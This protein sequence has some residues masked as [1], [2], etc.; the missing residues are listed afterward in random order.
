MGIMAAIDS[1]GTGAFLSV[2]AIFLTRS[3]GLS[4]AQ[5]GLGLGCGAAVGLFTTVPVGGLADR[6]GPRR[7]L[8]GVSLWRAA[9]YV[10]YPFVTSFA[11][12][13]A[14]VCV[15]GLVNEV[16]APMEQAMVS[17]AVPPD[18]R[19]HT[20][21]VMRSLRN[22]GFTVGVLLGGVALVADNWTAYAIVLFANAAS[23]V[24]LAVIAVTLPLA[25]AT[26]SA[27]ARREISLKVLADRPFLVLTGINAILTLHMPLLSVGIPLWIAEHSHAPRAIVG[28]L[29][30]VNTIL[31]ITLQVRASR[32]S[33]SPPGA[34]RRLRQ[35]GLALAVCCLLLAL[36]PRLG[37]VPAIA[38]LVAAMVALTGGELWQSAGGWGLSYALARPGQEGA[39]LSMFSL[40][41]AVQQIAAPVLV[42]TVVQ[43][44]TVGWVGL[45]ALVAVTG[46]IAPLTAT[47]ASRSMRPERSDESLCETA[48]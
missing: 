44:G 24:I 7:V 3:V 40:G 33:D 20:M 37:M 6:Y 23:F 19:V 5:V 16:A 35:A 29:L 32:G 31:C 22:V 21:A 1:A 39:Y 41:A 36:L 11:T 42:A 43:V 13:A 4:V 14:L 47:W 8:V 10:V 48:A 26:G 38:L 2:S 46:L 25:A 18:D 45:A 30:V 12:F 17:R 27:R 9:C 15:L 34:A 28:P